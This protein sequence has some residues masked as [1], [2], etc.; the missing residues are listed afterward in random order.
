MRRMLASVEPR[1]RREKSILGA[2]GEHIGDGAG[3]V[4]TH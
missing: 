2:V 3:K 1:P 4:G